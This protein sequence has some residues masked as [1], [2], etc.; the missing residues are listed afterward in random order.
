[1]SYSSL[2]RAEDLPWLF[3]GLRRRTLTR[4]NTVDTMLNVQ[5]ADRRPPSPAGSET[6]GRRVA[7][8]HGKGNWF[9]RIGALRGSLRL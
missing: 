3:A 4:E 2:L 6:A 9:A 8:A 1:M 7:G 5:W